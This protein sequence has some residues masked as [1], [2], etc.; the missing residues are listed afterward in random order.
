MKLKLVTFVE[1]GPKAH[2][3]IAITP[4]CRGRRYSIPWIAPPLLYLIM[5]SIKQASRTIL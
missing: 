2:F 1:G 5:L 3:S 4:R